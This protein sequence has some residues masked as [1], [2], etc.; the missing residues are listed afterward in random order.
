M[1]FGAFRRLSHSMSDLVESVVFFRQSNG[2]YCRPASGVTVQVDG[3]VA[4]APFLLKV[5]QKI[6]GD[7]FS[8][9]LE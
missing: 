7:E 6:C 4:G 2:W 3:V 9:I 8:M 1:C 5:G